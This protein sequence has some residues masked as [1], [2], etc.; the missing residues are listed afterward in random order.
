MRSSAKWAGAAAASALAATLAAE[1]GFRLADDGAF[2]HLNTYEADAE[3]GT[4]MRPG[5]TTRVAV[6]GNPATDVRINSAGFRGGEWGPQAPGEIVVVGDSQVFGL[7]VEEEET[8]SA[9]LAGVMGASVIN[10]GV[11]TYGPDEYLAVIRRLLADRNPATVILV[12]N[13]SNDFFE[14]EEAR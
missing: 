12:I 8:V 14:V 10:G 2:P 3:L 11:P 6:H 9:R 7:G 5:A 4:R 13:A 1:V